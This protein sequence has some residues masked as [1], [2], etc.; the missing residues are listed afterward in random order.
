M[1]LQVAIENVLSFRDEAVLNMVPVK[2]SRLMRDHI[3]EDAQNMKTRCLPIAAVYGANASGKTNLV[4]AIQFAKEFITEGTR[5]DVATGVTP[6]RLDSRTDIAPSRFEFVFKH[7]GIVYSYG[8]V[9]D[10]RDVREEWLFARFTASE[11]KVFERLTREGKVTVEAGHR[12]A[13]KRGDRQFIRFVGQGTRPNQL[14]LTEANIRN[15]D[16]I[17]PVIHWFR[18]HLH[19]IHPGSVYQMLAFRAHKDRDFADDLS[20]FLRRADTGV[21]SLE[22]KP[23]EFDPDRHLPAMPDDARDALLS[24]LRAEGPAR[25]LIQGPERSVVV[26]KDGDQQIRLFHLTARHTRQDGSAIDFELDEESDGTRR[27]MHLFPILS[28][29]RDDDRVYVIDELD[30][31]LHPHLSRLLI[32]MYLEGIQERQSR[33]QLI[34]TSHDT[35][36]FDR[37]LLRR[38]EIWLV[39]KDECGGSHLSSLAEFKVSEGLNYAN[40]YL[41]GRFGAIPSFG[42]AR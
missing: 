4:N 30:R 5:P 24:D 29:L 10:S 20:R 38:D 18:D 25:V 23:E 36:L 33:G 16:L 35:N 2:K 27:L 28:D 11:S 13:A 32:N 17:K 31:S 8:F 41:N 26:Y 22:C 1:L 14:F 39:E 40:G 15:V 42:G 6:F 21:E 34:F 12:L 37:K 7:E 19:V 9:I 3:I